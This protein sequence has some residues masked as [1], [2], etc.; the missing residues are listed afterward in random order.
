MK[1]WLVAFAVMVTLLGAA[2]G[3]LGPTLLDRAIARRV[4]EEA[5]K[6]GVAATWTGL[7]WGTWGL[8][9]TGVH[10]EHP[11]GTLDVDRL[12]V[13]RGEGLQPAAVRLTGV[14]G[15][16]DLTPAAG[17]P[18]GTPTPRVP[19]EVRD[20][21]LAV[22]RGDR[23]VRVELDE[24]VL[25]NRV[26]ARG[27]ALSLPLVGDVGFSAERRAD[28]WHLRGEP[29]VDLE[30]PGVGRVE[31]RHA[32]LYDGQLE[33][34]EATLR[35]AGLTIDL[36]QARYADGALTARGK[37]PGG[38]FDVAATP[39]GSVQLSVRGVALA[40]AHR[41]IRAGELDADLTIALLE[42][43]PEPAVLARA[44][45]DVRGLEVF[46]APVA[47]EPLRNIDVSLSADI[48]WEDGTLAVEDGVFRLGRTHTGF[49]LQVTD[50]LDDPVLDFSSDTDEI[51]CHE[52]VHALPDGLLGPYRDVVLR[53]FTAPRVRFHWPVHR[54]SA[55]SLEVKRLE[56]GCT[57]VALNAREE[58]WP[59]VAVGG[60]DDVDWLTQAFTLQV[61]EG[62]KREI[63]VG[64]RSGA[65]VP[66]SH[67][68][69]YVGAAM[70]LTEEVGFWRGRGISRP[71]IERALRLNLEGGRFVYGGST[72]NQQLVKNLFL[73]RKKTLARKVQEALV[74]DRIAKAVSKRRVL[75]LYLN[76]IEF[77]PDVFGIARAARYYFKKPASLL[78]PREAVF[79][80]MLKPSPRRGGTLRKRGAAP[81]YPWWRERAELVFQRL[82]EHGYLTEAQMEAQRPFHE[83][84]L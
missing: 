15:A 39:D 55:L 32:R 62:T 17:E 56:R 12:E 34:R 83:L 40:G 2:A 54:P 1:K 52:A 45:V 77:G 19:V 61:R 67:M 25:S 58:A 37:V 68:P 78:T 60:R 50:L 81:D 71:L 33:V 31:V 47:D 59:A 5:G 10:L 18:A 16:V 69:S 44:R 20:A 80:A 63:H 76:C 22:R 57:V 24:A 66:L 84:S 36:E 26:L 7:E 6:R 41:S 28:G 21:R 11:R 82:V 9:L 72:V 65:W 23:V 48:R 51:G 53:G 73:T 38:R 49:A 46:S 30:L 43:A 4:H 35:V 14:E 64:P 70:Y 27:R 74:A 42:V 8:G 75:E 29:L 3:L 79:L 13:H